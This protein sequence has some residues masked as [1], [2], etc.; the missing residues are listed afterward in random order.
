MDEIGVFAVDTAAH[1][2]VPLDTVEHNTAIARKS[3]PLIR[4]AAAFTFMR[5]WWRRRE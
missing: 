1:E 2:I 3:W 4:K 5:R